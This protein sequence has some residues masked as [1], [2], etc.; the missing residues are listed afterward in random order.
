MSL[1][2]RSTGGNYELGI[3]VD[4][5]LGSEEP[6]RTQGEPEFRR[7]GIVCQEVDRNRRRGLYSLFY[8][9]IGRGRSRYPRR[10][11]D[12]RMQLAMPVLPQPRHLD[13]DQRHTGATG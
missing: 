13:D 10:R 4:R 6:V 12:L 11:V 9:G 8:D 1:T 7:P 5:L 2:V 3:P